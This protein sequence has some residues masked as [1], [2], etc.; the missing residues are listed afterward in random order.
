MPA[1][2]LG[3]DPGLLRRFFSRKSLAFRAFGAY[4]ALESQEEHRYG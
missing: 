2:G 1:E 4:N 3:R